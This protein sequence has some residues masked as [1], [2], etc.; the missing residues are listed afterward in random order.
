ML[1]FTI[2][3]FLM[4]S[5]SFLAIGQKTR[6]I[7]EKIG[8]KDPYPILIKGTKL[9]DVFHPIYGGWNHQKNIPYFILNYSTNSKDANFQLK[10]YDEEQLNNDEINC[11]LNHQNIELILA[12]DFA[13]H[14]LFKH[15]IL[16]NIKL[17]QKIISSVITQ[18]QPKNYSFGI[19]RDE[20]IKRFSHYDHFITVSQKV[21]QE[22]KQYGLNFSEENY[23]F[24]HNCC[25]EE[26]A[27]AVAKTIFSQVQF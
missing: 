11:I 3:I 4:F 5:I 19:S 12:N 15:S 10:F 24:I 20:L 14:N 8:Y 9:K 25:N 26:N 16:P 22:W 21:L 17:H 23:H 1:R 2:F 13:F 27:E 7:S 6:N 18:T